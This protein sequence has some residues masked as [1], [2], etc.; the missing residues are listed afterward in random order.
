MKRKVLA[1]FDNGSSLLF[2][3][4]SRNSNIWGELLAAEPIPGVTRGAAQK[5]GK[6]PKRFPVAGR[7]VSGLQSRKRVKKTSPARKTSRKYF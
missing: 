5:S 4:L 3:Q 7:A 1:N 6:G 2:L